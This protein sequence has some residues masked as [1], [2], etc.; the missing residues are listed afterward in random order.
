[1]FNKLKVFIFCVFA[2]SFHGYTAVISYENS[3]QYYNSIDETLFHRNIASRLASAKIHLK[4]L[5]K[6]SN[7]AAFGLQITTT[8]KTTHTSDSVIVDFPNLFYSAYDVS[9]DNPKA[10]PRSGVQIISVPDLFRGDVISSQTKK[11]KL[12]DFCFWLAS[13]EH[14][15]DWGLENEIAFDAEIIK[16]G[17]ASEMSQITASGQKRDSLQSVLHCEQLFIYK[18]LTDKRLLRS[19]VDKLFSNP[20]INNV[21]DTN[22]TDLRFVLEICTYNDMCPKCFSSCFS[23][24]RELLFSISKEFFKKL[25]TNIIFKQYSDIFEIPFPLEIHISS[26]RPFFM[27]KGKLTRVYDQ[28]RPNDYTKFSLFRPTKG[29][30]NNGKIIQF[31]NPWI[32][33]HIF[34]YEVDNFIYSIQQLGESKFTDRWKLQEKFS[35]LIE[36]KQIETPIINEIVT[37]LLTQQDIFHRPDICCYIL[38]FFNELAKQITE[39]KDEFHT[40]IRD[41]IVRSNIND[42]NLLQFIEDLKKIQNPTDSIRLAINDQQMKL[43]TLLLLE[44]S[45][46]NSSGCYDFK[47]MIDAA[48]K[49]SL[50]GVHPTIESFIKTKLKKLLNIPSQENWRTLPLAYTRL[51]EI[52][53]R[54]LQ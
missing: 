53:Q 39:H 32:A 17:N 40:F 51:Q 27:Q 28:D 29:F 15:A 46:K 14:A 10:E 30:K 45:K 11:H 6:S 9:E 5:D 52:L 48:E 41:I 35:K 22:H 4:G 12:C 54:I 20:K 37:K 19:M 3:W 25:S 34:S 44:S 47:K 26:F 49:I 8:N 42:E 23:L 43:N 36:T 33:Q 2:L 16:K 31:F 50:K 18:L 21:L 38:P 24:Y 7:I 1:M 13:K